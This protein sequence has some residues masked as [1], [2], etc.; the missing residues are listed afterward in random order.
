MK[1]TSTVLEP[2]IPFLSLVKLID[3][4][5]IAN[6]K[7]RTH[8][9][10]LEVNNFTKQLQTQLL[11]CS[12][13]LCLHNLENQLTKTNLHIKNIAPSVIEQVIPSLLASKNNEKM[14]IKKLMLDENL[15][16]NRLYNTFVL[17]LLIEKDMIH[18]I[19]AEVHQEIMNEIINY[20]N[21]D[22]NSHIRYRDPSRDLVMA[23]YTRS[24]Y[25]NYKRDSRS[26]R[27]P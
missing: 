14:T 5:D 21:K 10:A 7:S 25:D 11:D 13:N 27:S 17:L 26:Y 19:E 3:A 4:D 8:D 24:R 20:Y 1:H 2:S 22:N 6:D 15:L 23:K 16:T 9:L 18:D 12:N